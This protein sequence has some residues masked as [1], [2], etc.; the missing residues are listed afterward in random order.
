MLHWFS[1]LKDGL[2][3]T[4]P[5]DKISNGD[6]VRKKSSRLE[7]LRPYFARHW[8]KGIVG[9]VLVLFVS[10][11]AFP[12]PLL[13][14]YLVDNVMLAKRLDLLVPVLLLMLLIKLLSMG[15]GVFQQ[16][17]FT[18][19][20]QQ[21]ILDLQHNLLDHTLHLPK[22]FFDNREVGYLISRLSADVSGLRWFFSS[23][24]VNLIGS[25]FRFIGG[26]IFLFYLE[27]RLG[28][29]TLV[30]LPLL[31]ISTRYFGNRF[32]AL[33]HHGMERSA[34]VLRRMEETIASLP[35][36][37]AFA[38]EKRETDRIISDV[39]ASQQIELEQTSVSTLANLV[40]GT[41]PGIASGLVLVAGAYWV[42]LGD[43]TV[44]SLLAFQAYLGFV[45]TPAM[46]LANANLQY[47]N[48]RTALERV[49]AILDLMPEQHPG[50]G[51]MVEHLR[52]DVRFEEVSFSY[53]DQGVVLENLSFHV[54][55]G[56]HVAIIG[57]SGAGKSTLISLILRFYRPTSGEIFFDDQEAPKFNLQSLRE[58]IGYVAQSTTLLAGTLSGNLRYG[59]VQASQA[60]IEH[61]ARVAGIHDFIM[62]LPGG[63]EARVD[64]RG[65]NLSEGQKQRISIARA[66]VKD[67]DILILDEPT[68]AL[69]GV[70]EQ[71]FV[72]A[73]EDV[74]RGRTLFLIAHRLS[75]VKK[76]SRILLL[77]GKQLV[78]EGSHHELIKNSEYY[79]SLVANQQIP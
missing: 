22:S 3:R 55:S 54:H 18:R 9:A 77:N 76:A 14:R 60:E 30:V 48:A 58:R 36:V 32:R 79:R 75:T 47:Q 72:D 51:Q 39:E 38:S 46:S 10:L 61:A 37:K 24:I 16:Y 63:Y 4:I 13:F 52:G 28:L 35:L 2:K 26:I 40:L 78:S 66:L 74:A 44:G 5:P 71:A 27:W 8:S 49:S 21:M 25:F 70:A 6:P 17:Y 20:E 50:Q 65:L 12:Q 57:P 42:I 62:S 11:L 1:S 67:P 19:F 31:V 68:S 15:S 29:M 56:E 33:S 59:D 69:D 23:Q 34:N 45:F 73:L 41:V 53:N 7:N 43:W 64:E